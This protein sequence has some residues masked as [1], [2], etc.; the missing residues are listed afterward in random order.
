MTKSCLV[1]DPLSFSCNIATLQY[2]VFI[3]SYFVAQEKSFSVCASNA[4]LTGKL[5]AQRVIYPR[6]ATCYDSNCLSKPMEQLHTCL[7]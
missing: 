4:L 5:G 1:N 2:T 7:I 3:Y 6:A